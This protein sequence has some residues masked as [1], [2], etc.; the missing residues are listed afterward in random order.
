MSEST[1]RMTMRLLALIVNWQE[2]ERV[3]D[4]V[5]KN[6]ILMHTMCHGEGTA[7]S[8]ILD[9]I[10]LGRSEK[11][12]LFCVA[13]RG[14]IRHLLIDLNR[15]LKLVVP[16]NGIAFT[17][18]F[19]G[20]P[21]SLYTLLDSQSEQYLSDAM[22][23]DQAAVPANKTESEV[24]KMKAEPA[25][26]LIMAIINHGYTDDMM[27]A[28]R[29]AGARG[30]TVI[31]ARGREE[32]E[33]R[34]MGIALAE[35]KEIVLILTKKEDTRSIMAAVNKQCGIKTAAKGYIISLPVDSVAGLESVPLFA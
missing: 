33:E 22:R 29:L 21:N 28:A 1:K 24:E 20:M 13:P 17:M 25:F 12:V 15:E 23:E 18:P 34:F 14:L 32:G 9:W 30:G 5:S 11:M 6:H 27:T 26:E 10:G 19:S 8:E 3:S 16:G 35:E 31:K 7:S 2:M 4:L